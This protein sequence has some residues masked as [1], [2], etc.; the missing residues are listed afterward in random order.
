ML[1]KRE[2]LKKLAQ[3]GAKKRKAEKE[4]EENE[5]KQKELG[6]QAEYK[7]KI[8]DACDCVAEY[9]ADAAEDGDKSTHYRLS[10]YQS[11]QEWYGESKK[12][13]NDIIRKLKK[14][15]KDG[16]YT[17]ELCMDDWSDYYEDWIDGEYQGQRYERRYYPSV[18][19]SWK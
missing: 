5:K 18:K 1:P 4:E 13:G 17:F 2:T 9:I 19:V 8:D 12:F 16:D 14:L 7:K 3:D 10:D 15:D 11:I 6:K